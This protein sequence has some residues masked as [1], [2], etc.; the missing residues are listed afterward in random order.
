MNIA[1]IYVEGNRLQTAL[2]FLDSAAEFR[3]KPDKYQLL[4][5]EIEQLQISAEKACNIGGKHYRDS[6][7][8][9][10]AKKF[11]QAGDINAENQEAVYYFHMSKGFM[12]YHLRGEGQYWDWIVGFGEAANALPSRGEPH[13]LSAICYYKKDSN[14]FDNTIRELNKALELELEPY[15]QDKAEAKLSE[16]VARKKKMDAF[17]GK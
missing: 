10:A 13:Y 12:L 2:V 8:R 5:D 11:Q 9:A 7:F 17:W 16:V 4:R 6:D 14:D 3:K 1:G 15:Y